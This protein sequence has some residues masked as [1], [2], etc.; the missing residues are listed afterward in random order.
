MLMTLP[1]LARSPDLV[2]YNGRGISCCGFP[3]RHFPALQ[4]TIVETHVVFV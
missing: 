2:L 1:I 3:S 4:L